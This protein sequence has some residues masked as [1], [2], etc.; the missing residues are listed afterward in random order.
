MALVDQQTIKDLEFQEI[1]ELLMKACIGDTARNQ[2]EKLMPIPR[3]KTLREA[4]GRLDEL[5]K[6]KTEGPLLITHWGMSGP[7]ILKASSIGARALRW[8]KR[9]YHLFRRI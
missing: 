3:V 6:I 1:R 4:L 9:V 8:L 5:F 2:M 7:T